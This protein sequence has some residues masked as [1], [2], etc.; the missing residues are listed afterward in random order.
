MKATQTKTPAEIS[1]PRT[2]QV[3]TD[4]ELDRLSVLSSVEEPLIRTS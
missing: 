1:S 3:R 4:A 2:A